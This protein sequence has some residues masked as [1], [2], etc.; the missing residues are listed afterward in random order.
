MNTFPFKSPAATTV[1]AATLS[2]SPAARAATVPGDS[3]LPK[4]GAMAARGSADSSARAI[5]GR[6]VKNR[7]GT[8]LGEIKNLVVDTHSGRVLFAT[9]TQGGL[10]GIGESIHAAPYGLLEIPQPGHGPIILGTDKA[11]LD[12]GPQVPEDDPAWFADH[13]DEVYRLY[14]RNLNEAAGNKPTEMRHYL[15][16]DQISGRDVRHDGRSIGAIEDVIINNRDHQC[17][18]L[19]DPNDAFAGTHRKFLVRLN[20][21]TRDPQE[22]FDT[23]LATS[24][25]SKAAP[26]GRDWGEANGAG[27]PSLWEFANGAGHPMNPP[28]VVNAAGRASIADIRRALRDDPAIGPSAASRLSFRQDQNTL[29][30]RGTVATN[31]LG[32]R[33]E[34]QLGRLAAGWTVDSHLSV[35]NATE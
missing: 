28:A 9:I 34:N 12:S 18:A 23:P 27:Y 25:F 3:P 17:A 33:I 15:T 21:L 6:N 29:V 31:A 13:G 30:V 22:N 14:G 26:A 4:N 7:D 32:N 19:L 24:D 10:F 20:Q 5:V 16:V 1:I 35:R 8:D 11:T 2:L